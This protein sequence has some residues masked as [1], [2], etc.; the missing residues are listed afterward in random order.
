MQW[1]LAPTSDGGGVGGVSDALVLLAES[2]YLAVHAVA[3]QTRLW[4]EGSLEAQHARLP[5]STSSSHGVP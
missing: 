3:N 1:A 2:V 4:G 5:Q